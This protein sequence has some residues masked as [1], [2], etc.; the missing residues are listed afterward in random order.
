MESVLH[1]LFLEIHT[2]RQVLLERPLS[3]GGLCLSLSAASSLYSEADLAFLLWLA[4]PCP[5]PLAGVLSTVQSCIR[6]GGCGEE[7]SATQQREQ[8]PRHMP[9]RSLPSQDLQLGT[10]SRVPPP[11]P[12]PL[13]LLPGLFLTH[14]YCL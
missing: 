8:R 6:G 1:F 14:E 12:S 2:R 11:M 13:T 10:S 3:V 4:F 5:C 9:P 7:M